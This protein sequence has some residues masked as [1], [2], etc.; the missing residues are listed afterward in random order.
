[1]VVCFDGRRSLKMNVYTSVLLVTVLLLTSVIMFGRSN[2]VFTT[3]NYDSEREI[4][5]SEKGKTN[6][7]KKEV[8]QL[9]LE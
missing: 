4:S 1:M 9:S 8:G 2:T 6:S 7:F 3:T 5:A